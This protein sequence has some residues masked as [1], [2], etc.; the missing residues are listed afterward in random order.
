M[1]DGYP[2]PGTLLDR[3]AEALRDAVERELLTPA[4]RAWMT[5]TASRLQALADSLRA[6]PEPTAQT[7]PTPLAKPERSLSRKEAAVVIGV[8]ANSLLNWE[9]RGLLKPRRDANGW[10]VYSRADL[11]RAMAIAAKVEITA[12]PG[13]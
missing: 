5:S 1:D 11:A 13:S 8:H 4:D 7:T 12:E 9:R 3:A 6:K 10:R 2:A